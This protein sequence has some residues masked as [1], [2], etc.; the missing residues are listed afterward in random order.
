MKSLKYLFILL[1]FSSHYS[2]FSQSFNY[3]TSWEEINELKQK[4]LFAQALEKTNAIFLQAQKEG[5]SL[6]T[7]K[8]LVYKANFRQ[9]YEE[10]AVLKSIDEVQQVIQ[11]VQ[12]A[13]KAMLTIAL[14]DLYLQ[15][16][17]NNQWIIRERKEIAGPASKNIE[18]WSQ[19]NFSDQIEMLINEALKS[20]RDLKVIASEN[21][22][23][24]FNS[25]ENSSV[26]QP[27]LLDFVI[28]KA[29]D[30]YSS[31]EFSQQ[32]QNDLVL[33]NNPDYYHDYQI[34]GTVKLEAN[35]KA[36][37]KEKALVLFQRLIK[38]HEGRKD[39][40]PLIF[41][42][43]KR[44]DFL[45]SQGQLDDSD[46]IILSSLES[47][48]KAYK[49]IAGSDLIAFELTE[50]WKNL[51]DE[52]SLQKADQ[53]CQVM[54]ESN[55]E[56]EYFEGMKKWLNQEKLSFNFNE[57]QVPNQYN[58]TSIEYQN[59]EKAYFKIVKLDKNIFV[60]RDNNSQVDFE[61][62][63]AFPL[64]SQFDIVVSNQKYL[65]Q[66]SA[67]IEIPPLDLGHYAIISSTSPDFNSKSDLLS[68]G[69]FWVS[70]IALINRNNDGHFLLTDRENGQA[71]E[72]AE[73]KVFSSQWEYSTRSNITK[74]EETLKSD[75]NGFF[76]LQDQKG[77]RN[78]HLEIAKGNDEWVS[79]TIYTHDYQS[80]ENS[81]EKH[82]FFT[83][84]AIYRPG[85]TVYFKGILTQQKGNDIN[86]LP[87]QETEVKFYST[88]GKVLQTLKLISNEYGSVA[89]SFVCPLAGLSGNMRISD[90]KGSVSF[91]MEEYKR[92]QFEVSIEKP[93]EEF[94]LN[95]KISLTGKAS[96]YAGTGVQNAQVKYR[97]TR[98]ADM[99]WRWTFWPQI[100]EKNIAAGITKTDEN[101]EFQISFEAVAPK[102]KNAVSW[103]NYSVIAEITD[104]TGETHT[105]T[106]NI[107][108]GSQSLFISTD[109]PEIMDIEKAKEVLV[110]AQT[111]NGNILHSQLVFI[112]EKLQNPYPQKLLV[113]LEKDTL[114]IS[115]KN[116]QSHFPND[117]FVDNDYKYPVEAIVFEKSLDTK[118]D[119]IIPKSIF[120]SLPIGRYRMTLTAKDKNGLEVK[121][122]AET[123]IFSS[124]S[125]KIPFSELNFYH[126]D[127]S[128]AKVGDTITLSVG[129]SFKKPNIFFQISSGD[130]LVESAWMSSPKGLQNIQIPIKEEYRGGLDLQVFT[131]RD[132][133]FFSKEQHINI[134][135]DNKE[136]D[137]QLITKRNPMEP[138][139]KE[140]WTLSVKNKKGEAMAAELLAGMY[141]ASL[142]VF[143]ENHWNLWPYQNKYAKYNWNL[144]HSY[145]QCL[146][147]Q[148]N[149]YLS[150]PISY[151]ILQ[152]AWA[153]YFHNRV[154]YDMMTKGAGVMPMMAADNDIHETENAYVVRVKGSVDKATPSTEQKPKEEASLSP[155]KNLQETAFFFPQLT[156]DEEGFVQLHFTSPEALSRWKLMVLATSK[157]MEIGSLSQEFVT[158]KEVMV[159]PNL[160]RFLRGGDEITLSSKILNLL[161]TPQDIKAK[162]EILDAKTMKPI[163]IL[164]EGQIAE[165]HVTLEAKGQKTVNWVVQVPEEVGAV[166]IRIMAIGT[167]H[168]DGE[169]HMLP[170]LSQLHFLTDTYPFSL[171]KRSSITAEDLNLKDEERQNS[172]E[173][174]LEITSN[175]LWY[176]VQALPN[177]ELPQKPNA[178]S[179]FNYYFI[180]AMAADI[181]KKNPEIQ[182]VFKQWKLLSPE[183]LESELFQNPELKKVLIEETPWI[184]N[185]ENQSQRKKQ[186]ARLFDENNLNYQLETALDKL[187]NLQKSDGGFGWIDG[188]KTSVYISSQIAQG[189]GQLKEAGILD[190]D[191]NYQQKSLVNQLV[192]YLD[193]ELLITY[194]QAQRKDGNY[195]S[196]MAYR[197]LISRAY[198][199]DLY[200][201]NDTQKAFD[202]F[203][204]QWKDKKTQKSIEEKMNLALVLWYK[205]KKS[206]A[207]ELVLALKDIALKD[208]NG[209]IY[210]RDF[211]RYESVRK[212]AEMIEL[213]ELCQMESEWIE[214][215]KLWLLQQKRANDWGDGKATAQACFAMLSHANS[216]SESAKVYLM[217]GG[218]EQFIEGNSGTGYFKIT[219]KGAEIAKALE[220]LKI[221]KEGKGMVFGAFY[222]QYFEK[223]SQIDA[224]D[225][226]VKIEKQIFVA[227]TIGSENQLS[228]LSENTNIQ[229]GDRI[230][231]RMLIKNEQAM[232]F[233]HL[234]D[235]LPAGFEN[236]NPLSGYRWQGDLSYYQ[237][238]GD[239]ATDYFINH[240]PKGNFLIEYELNATISGK[241]NLGPSEIQSIY[242]PEF[243]GHSEGGMIWVKP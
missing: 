2:L 8:S 98:S 33:L 124:N 94:S 229:L 79:S 63:L 193:D 169:E 86:I 190:L 30:F 28:W 170:V 211:Q 192:K 160:P 217:I 97:V 207:N 116:L 175:P 131:M 173:L 10:K 127:Q 128:N 154:V 41:E 77:N 25:Q 38:T 144:N 236:Q 174:T 18:E 210:W 188:M 180:Q 35:Q 130:S 218:K 225:G 167:A 108:I 161:E 56:K 101:G 196:G 235:Y 149:T 106:Q 238:P 52:K 31:S 109:L 37:F 68:I 88:Q 185:A 209:G 183:E 139:A 223:M 228:P 134:P 150:S 45:S 226:G 81:Y 163:S 40:R 152:Y 65:A 99:P 213:F 138:G 125:N 230:L 114:I 133:A 145:F 46:E 4:D 195:Y 84:R 50:K 89:G 61:K 200:P 147:N 55:I 115:P 156:T 122:I 9:A 3:Q 191:K 103:Y 146:D 155:R 233:V 96:F 227:K 143:A 21:W 178:L 23:E 54:I 15:Y 219:W 243:G 158:Q 53:I 215:M 26:Y 110:K 32:E 6:Q 123:M 135:F 197:I 60:K 132:N 48:F 214:G 95:E 17:Q 221:R 242:A 157:N 216:L 100:S 93:S 201:L 222:D 206:K 111:A 22:K 107:R 205:G 90:G 182:E 171:S 29:I 202:F 137:V 43:V 72:G 162:L 239:V 44:F 69:D 42:E 148:L 166:I 136:L 118:I 153:N 1:A 142:D 194:A 119:S 112:L 58:W 74:L 237:S 208:P 151:E 78:I 27:F 117:I 184:L 12:G 232:D 14:S 120:K 141:D 24:V 199:I 189:L 140:Q 87:N 73:I 75:R 187:K 11:E 66:K 67:V 62:Y 19:Q 179:W 176:V 91:K 71:I 39:P 92:P 212:Q 5:N 113:K 57:I 203:L 20:E 241:L 164:A 36:S 198:F 76:Q 168:S 85:Q 220:A 59:L 49:G 47:L 177:Y 70:R 234:R 64:A 165:Q 83:D 186:I 129:S 80:R 82:Y 51:N 204:N 159:M 16:Y 240:L 102:L 104:E 7:V 231:V 126:L 224:H 105:Q 181:V 172:D 34:F 121:E 13:E